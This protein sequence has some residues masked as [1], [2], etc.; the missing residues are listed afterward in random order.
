MAALLPVKQEDSLA[1]REGGSMAWEPRG[2]W[3]AEAATG[4]VR[5]G[6]EL[7]PRAEPARGH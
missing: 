3:R 5:R 2:K 7:E 4:A 1:P 6:A